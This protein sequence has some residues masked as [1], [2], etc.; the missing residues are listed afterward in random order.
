MK[1]AGFLETRNL[2]QRSALSRQLSAKTKEYHK[3]ATRTCG[4]SEAIFP[5]FLVWLTAES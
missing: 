3:Q 5:I 1:K 4:G 2:C